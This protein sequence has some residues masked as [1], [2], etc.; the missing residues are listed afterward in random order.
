MTDENSVPLLVRLKDT[1]PHVFITTDLNTSLEALKA[2][3]LAAFRQIG[4][5]SN[6]GILMLE[7]GR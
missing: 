7:I 5:L 6:R 2:Q 3:A 1:A 4:L